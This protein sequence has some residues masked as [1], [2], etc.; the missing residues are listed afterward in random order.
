MDE[1]D[2]RLLNALNLDTND[3]RKDSSPLNKDTDF[4]LSKGDV[5]DNIKS[6]QEGQN[7][8]SIGEMEENEKLPEASVLPNRPLFAFKT[9][10]FGF[11]THN[12]RKFHRI[13]NSFRVSK[14]RM[15]QFPENSLDEEPNVPTVAPKTPTKLE[16]FLEQ[17]K[18]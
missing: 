13:V 16:S 12:G 2:L 18:M 7:D 3:T 10:R 5:K 4:Y 9:T 11:K 8:E 6:E 1:D 14:N 15:N 17:F